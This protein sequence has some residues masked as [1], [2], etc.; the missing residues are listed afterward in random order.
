MLLF[1]SD[2]IRRL[3]VQG[4]TADH[5][6]FGTPAGLLVNALIGV[7]WKHV[8][9]EFPLLLLLSCWGVCGWTKGGA[10]FEREIN[11]TRS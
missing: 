6:F 8:A 10:G 5:L 9:T 2:G 1:S 11:R 4:S 7:R 3:S